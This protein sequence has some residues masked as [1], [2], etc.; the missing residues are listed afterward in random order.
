[1]QLEWDD[2]PETV[3]NNLETQLEKN[4]KEFDMVSLTYLLRG[5]VFMKYRWYEKKK[6]RETILQCFSR[7]FRP[8]KEQWSD[9]HFAA[10]IFDLG[11][12]GMKWVDLPT[13]VQETIFNEVGERINSFRSL[14]VLLEG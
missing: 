6:I 9:N 4:Y 7:A 14:S 5:S 13:D 3:K 11:K 10:C 8:S 12:V 2:I 1:V